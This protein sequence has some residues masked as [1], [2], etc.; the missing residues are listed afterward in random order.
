MHIERDRRRADGADR[1]R[2]LRRL[3]AGPHEVEDALGARTGPIADAELEHADAAVH[4][5]VGG[6]VHVD[7]RPSGRLAG[8][9]LEH[10]SAELVVRPEQDRE[11]EAVPQVI[12]LRGDRD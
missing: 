6:L 11:R 1:R 12:G 2:G 10:V 4:L 7:W 8:G 3:A 5:V 9:L